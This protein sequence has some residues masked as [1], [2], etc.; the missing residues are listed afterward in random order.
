MNAGWD[1]TSSKDLVRLDQRT[2]ARE[3]ISEVGQLYLV[4]Q[5]KGL[6]N[7]KIELATLDSNLVELIVRKVFV[8]LCPL[9]L[10]PQ[11]TVKLH[12]LKPITIHEKSFFMF[13]STSV[14]C[15]REQRSY[16]NQVGAYQ[17]SSDKRVRK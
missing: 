13:G 4:Q 3:P 8:E 14:K 16:F 15:E 11:K 6:P 9:K 12:A 7:F 1:V 2:L 17:L 10:I 5:D